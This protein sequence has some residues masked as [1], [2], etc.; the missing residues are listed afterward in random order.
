[1][2]L[3]EWLT[4]CEDL[5]G[6]DGATILGVYAGY[7]LRGESVPEA[8]LQPYIDEVLSELEYVLGPADSP[9]G[10]LRARDGRR[11]PFDVRYIEIGN[12]DWFSDTYGYR[13]PAFYAQ[14]S[15]A[16]PNLTFIATTTKGGVAFPS[17]VQ[18]DQHFYG[19]GRNFL[20]LFNAWDNTPRSGSSSSPILVTE[21]SVQRFAN[22]TFSPWPFM[23][24]S[25]AE[26]VMALGIERNSDIVLTQMYAPV[27]SNL[28]YN[29]EGKPRLISFDADQESGKTLLSTSY[30]VLQLLATT[31]AQRSR[32][33][34]VKQDKGR[35]F[36]PVYWAAS[37]DVDGNVMYVKFANSGEKRHQVG[38][39]LQ[40]ANAT[41]VA[42]GE[43]DMN[44]ER[45]PDKIGPKA[46]EVEKVEGG[47]RVV[48]PGWSV[49]VVR[50]LVKGGGMGTEG[51]GASVG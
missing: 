24:G 46:L 33:L 14:L 35:G 7:S 3:F 29:R 8:E 36:Y 45:E 43:L 4:F 32:N 49:A 40:C 31:H 19:D 6:A 51:V 13:W 25:V 12:E 22:Q 26:A 28:H 44:T 50:C 16:Y 23:A 20:G 15:A 42:G 5:V 30:H 1:M 17:S 34:E 47:S 18:F 39:D 27:L 48:L 10:K 2:G 38:L 9:Y 37:L 11:E 21:Y 41:V